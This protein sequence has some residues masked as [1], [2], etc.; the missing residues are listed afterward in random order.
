M[1]RGISM[2]HDA[3]PRAV[4]TFAAVWGGMGTIGATI[5][6][7][8]AGR[9]QHWPLF[10]TQLDRLLYRHTGWIAA[11]TALPLVVPMLVRRT[12]MAY[13]LALLA[14][15]LGAG[16]FIALSALVD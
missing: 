5:A 7:V 3:R 13:L 11:L 6:C 1:G 8:V 15:L 2:G 12:R 16:V 10:G 9:E 4:I 14:P